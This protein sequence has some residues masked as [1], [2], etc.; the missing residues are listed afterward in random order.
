VLLTP[1][2]ARPRN[3][4]GGSQPTASVRPPRYLY[5]FCIDVVVTN[6]Q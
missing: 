2:L 5:E 4:S 1:E 6:L 3:I